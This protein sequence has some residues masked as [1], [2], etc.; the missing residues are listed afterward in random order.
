MFCLF[1]FFNRKTG[2]IRLAED[3]ASDITAS[4]LYHLV[5]SVRNIITDLSAQ[6]NITVARENSPEQNQFSLG[7]ENGYEERDYHEEHVIHKRVKLL[8]F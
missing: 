4:D 5:I 1:T 6:T 8:A 7:T 2:R 3:R